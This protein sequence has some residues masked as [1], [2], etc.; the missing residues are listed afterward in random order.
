MVSQETCNIHARLYSNR[1]TYPGEGIAE[2]I[3]ANDIQKEQWTLLQQL[4]FFK[5]ARLSQTW[6]LRL[7]GPDSKLQSWLAD[8][9]CQIL[10]STAEL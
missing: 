7:L 8:I 10:Q 2:G 3:L 4:S 5:L 1:E 6:D 9:Q